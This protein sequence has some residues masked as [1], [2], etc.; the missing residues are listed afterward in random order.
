MNQTTHPL[1]AQCARTMAWQTL[2]KL[3]EAYDWPYW[4]YYGYDCSRESRQRGNEKRAAIERQVHLMLE[5][6]VATADQIRVQWAKYA[7]RMSFGFTLTK[8]F[9]DRIQRIASDINNRKEK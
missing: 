7:E 4:H 2:L 1:L 5:D 8:A 9:D 6:G 3:I